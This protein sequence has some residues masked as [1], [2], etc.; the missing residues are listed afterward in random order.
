MRR[1]SF[2]A[3]AA[4]LPIGL[5]ALAAGAPAPAGDLEFFTGQM[6][7]Q[8]CSSKPADSDYAERQARCFGYVI[9]VSDAEQAA[10]GAGGR[11]RVCLPSTA[12]AP[13]L[14]GTVERYLEEHPDKRPLAAQDLVIEALAA[15][16]PCR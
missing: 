10:Q 3:L 8:R 5:A 7:Y 12:A 1:R 13:Q 15:Q 6:L 9:G 11:E 4:A 2:A 14:Q 16:Y